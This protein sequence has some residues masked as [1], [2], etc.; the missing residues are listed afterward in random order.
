MSL[1]FIK[2]ETISNRRWRG[3]ASHPAKGFDFWQVSD[4]QV[5]TGWTRV[6]FRMPEHPSAQHI[7]TNRICINCLTGGLAG[8]LKLGWRSGWARPA[9][10][11][12]SLRRKHLAWALISCSVPRLLTDASEKR[13]AVSG[14]IK[15]DSLSTALVTQAIPCCW[16]FL[17]GVVSGVVFRHFASPADGSLTPLQ[18]GKGTEVTHCLSWVNEGN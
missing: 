11:S 1:C 13:Q 6:A 3:M 2:A 5:H 17:H 4:P 18:K 16:V 7:P 9:S 8:T 12:N 14:L 15:P 10:V